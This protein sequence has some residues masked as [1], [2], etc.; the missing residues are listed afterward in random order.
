MIP[1]AAKA[2]IL[3]ML[4]PRLKPRAIKNFL[5]T[6]SL[7]P[8]LPFCRSAPHLL[9]HNNLLR[10]RRILSGQRHKINSTNLKRLKLLLNTIET[11]RRLI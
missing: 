6:S 7:Q 4:H 9:L 10:R 1:L 11:N 5:C 3:L 2:K 8:L